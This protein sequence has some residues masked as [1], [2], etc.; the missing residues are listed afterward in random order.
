MLTNLSPFAREAL[1]LS[2]GLLIGL[3][4]GR[5]LWRV[6]RDT[7]RPPVID[8]ITLP[9]RFKVVRNDGVVV[10]SGD[11]ARQAGHVYRTTELRSKEH[12]DFYDDDQWRGVRTFGSSA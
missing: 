10:Y 12:V 9:N 11:D 3:L 2:F 5:L 7:G 6:N 1:S 8:R 4:A